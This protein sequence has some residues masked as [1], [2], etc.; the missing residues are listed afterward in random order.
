EGF[1]N[2]F[3]DLFGIQG[4]SWISTPQTAV[5]TL[6]LLKI[7]QF[8]APMIIFLAGLKQIPGELYEAASI[9]GAGRW[10]RFVSITLPLL[11]PIIFFNLVMQI[12]QSFQAFTPAYIISDG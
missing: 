6:V 1:F 3:L 7:W 4:I 9:D 12:I 11:T 8:G 2:Q 10:K 5:Y